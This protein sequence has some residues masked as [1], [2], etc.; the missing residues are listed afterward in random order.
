MRRCAPPFFSNYPFARKLPVCAYDY[1][2]SAGKIACREKIEKRP[3][4]AITMGGKWFS[5]PIWRPARTAW[6]ARGRGF[7]SRHPD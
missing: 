6:G 7:E 5:V 4:V 3:F 1:P 2:F